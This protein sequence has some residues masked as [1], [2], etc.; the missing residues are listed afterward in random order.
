MFDVFV[1]LAERWIIT[2]ELPPEPVGV[3]DMEA[4][5]GFLFLFLFDAKDIVP[6][7]FAFC[8]VF[9]FS[10]LGCCA[11]THNVVVQKSVSGYSRVQTH[12][13]LYWCIPVVL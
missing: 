8:L 10:R 5:M 4:L 13:A 3:F 6:S 11:T 1:M 9:F 2:G 7:F 12:G